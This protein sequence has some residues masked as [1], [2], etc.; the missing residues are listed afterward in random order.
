MS[1]GITSQTPPYNRTPFLSRTR[2]YLSLP[3]MSCPVRSNECRKVGCT[4]HLNGLFPT[5]N[6]PCPQG[7]HCPVWNC[8]LRHDLPTRNSLINQKK[9]SGKPGHQPTP[10][11]KPGK[12]NARPSQPARAASRKQTPEGQLCPLENGECRKNQCFD[13]PNNNPLA[14]TI[15]PCLVGP[16]C[17]NS[18][19][20]FSHDPKVAGKC[21]FVAYQCRKYACPDHPNNASL[22][23]GVMSCVPIWARATGLTARRNTPRTLENPSRLKRRIHF[24]KLPRRTHLFPT[25]EIRVLYQLKPNVDSSPLGTKSKPRKGKLSSRDPLCLLNNRKQ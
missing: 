2:H 3:P 22:T 7:A 16:T 25:E 15:A 20:K 9:K 18:H 10:A 8:N 13:H 5:N 19:C 1:H 14:T 4:D 17:R 21:P 12:H 11:E 6:T 24:G 23:L